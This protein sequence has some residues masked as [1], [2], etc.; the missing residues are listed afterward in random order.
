MIDVPGAMEDE[1]DGAL[2][3]VSELEK[4]KEARQRFEDSQIKRIVTVDPTLFARP[5]LCDNYDC[6]F[7]L[8]SAEESGVR[9]DRAC[10]RLCIQ[11]EPVFEKVWRGSESDWS[12]RCMTYEPVGGAE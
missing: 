4:A 2:L 12:L 5:V 9:V 1:D 6:R 11:A 3:N 8:V 10:S 7:L